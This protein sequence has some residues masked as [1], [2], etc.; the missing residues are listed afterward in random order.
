MHGSTLTTWAQ[1]VSSFHASNLGSVSL[2]R[3]VTKIFP[4]LSP[5]S[6]HK[7]VPPRP[8]PPPHTCL[9]F[10]PLPQTPLCIHI[11]LPVPF[12]FPSRL[13]SSKFPTPE[14][15]LSHTTSL[16]CPPTPAPPVF[17]IL[18]APTCMDQYIGLMCPP[19]DVFGCDATCI[20]VLVNVSFALPLRM[21]MAVLFI[22]RR[23]RHLQP[24]VL[25]QVH[26]RAPLQRWP[27]FWICVRGGGWPGPRPCG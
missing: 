14:Q 15:W 10:N 12:S 1:A 23:R 9:S 18:F 5:S 21:R 17:F 19:R 7:R 16:L 25:W 27:P 20:D 24:Q 22:G 8:V 4:P 13:P 3:Q 11:I 6:A 2:P 26:S